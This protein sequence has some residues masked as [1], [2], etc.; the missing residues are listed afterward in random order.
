MCCFVCLF[1][2][3]PPA[4]TCVDLSVPS[5]ANNPYTCG[6]VGTVTNNVTID[7]TT[8]AWELQ[9]NTSAPTYYDGTPWDANYANPTPWLG[10][11]EANLLDSRTTSSGQSTN[12]S[13]RGYPQCYGTSRSSNCFDHFRAQN[14]AFAKGFYCEGTDKNPTFTKGDD[15]PA[16]CLVYG[17]GNKLY[18]MR[19]HPI[20]DQFA[21]ITIQGSFNTTTGWKQL[22]HI[23]TQF[24]V[25]INGFKTPTRH[26][27]GV[28]TS[29]ECTPTVDSNGNPIPDPSDPSRDLPCSFGAAECT[30]VPF[31]TIV[32]HLIQGKIDYIEFDDDNTL[33]G[34][35]LSID[36]NCAI[37]ISTCS[38]SISYDKTNTAGGTD[39]DFK[40]Y[41]SWEGTDSEN[42]FLTSAGRRLSQFRRWSLNAVYNQASNFD[43]KDL[44]SVPTGDE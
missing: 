39:C 44:P 13:A 16:I 36:G 17:G 18:K 2:A 19:F 23:G 1:L 28:R 9:T 20:V 7:A 40:V 26:R 38:S 27:Y 34:N 5:G 37:P 30:V 15:S 21:L 32:I 4:S 31:H 25:E 3:S 6:C 29:D 11:D 24:Q 42:T 33:C 22:G 14:N 41:V 35:D 8:G 43:S 10:T 12:A